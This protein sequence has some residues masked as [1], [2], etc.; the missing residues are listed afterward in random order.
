GE[1]APSAQ[2]IAYVTGTTQGRTDYEQHAAALNL[3]G[4]PFSTWA[5]PVSIATGVEYRSEKQATTADPIAEAG[6]F[7]ANNSRSYGGKFDVV[8]GYVETVLPLA[9]DASWARSLDLNGALRIA[10]YSTAAGTQVTWKV[11]ATY[12]PVA[13]LLFRGTRSRDIRAPNIYEL[14]LRSVPNTIILNYPPHQGLVTSYLAGNPN[15]QP[16]KA[17]TLAVGVSYRPGLVSGLQVSADFY[18]I[19]VRDLVSSL[20][21]QAVADAC[22][23]GQVQ[24]CDFLTFHSHGVPA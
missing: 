14:N 1:G 20:G 10:D 8:E 21:T 11:G 3:A 22:R 2:A 6:D 13:G 19:H 5:G 24:Y 9:S 7:E 17:D 15:L 18:Q 23:T 16:E 12:E 4:N